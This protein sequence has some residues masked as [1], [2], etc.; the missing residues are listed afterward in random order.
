MISWLHVVFTF[1][2]EI[3]TLRSECN[4]IRSFRIDTIMLFIALRLCNHDFSRCVCS[5]DWV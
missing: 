3:M 1:I 4:A 5:D 2:D